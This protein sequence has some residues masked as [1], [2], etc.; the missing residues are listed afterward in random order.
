MRRRFLRTAA[1][2]GLLAAACSKQP[3][4]VPRLDGEWQIE[5]RSPAKFWETP[6]TS[7]GRVTLRS[8]PHH[9]EVCEEDPLACSSN[10][11][12][13][14][15]VST[16]EI[17]GTQLKAEVVGA[18]LDRRKILI[19]LGGCCDHGELTLVGRFDHGDI[20]GQWT[21]TFLTDGRQGRFTMIRVR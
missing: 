11:Q 5:L 15:R 16:R 6:R 3:E 8:A 18:V 2:L 1:L 10:V 14:A 13:T 20:Q 12:G 17:V 4:P 21:E 7:V 9:G 19:V